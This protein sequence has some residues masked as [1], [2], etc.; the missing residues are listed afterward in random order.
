[1]RQILRALQ[2]RNYRLY[3]AGQGVSLVGTW[4]Q[5]LA[6]SWLVYRLTRSTVLLGTVGFFSQIPSLVVTPLAG[7]LADRGNRLRKLIIIQSL[8]M[9]QAFILAFLVLTG[10]IEVWH[11][12]VLS[13]LLGCVTAFDIPTRQ[14]FVIEMIGQREDLGNAIALNSSLVNGARLIGPSLAGI[15]IAVIGE[16]ACFLLNGISYLAVLGALL[17]MRMHPGERISRRSRIW[18]E[19]REGFAYAFGFSPIRSLL[20]LLALMSLAAISYQVLMPVFAGE[21]LHGGPNTLGFLMGFSGVGALSGSVYL[22][23]RRNVR[24]LGRVI[25]AASLVFGFGMIAFSFSGH[26]WLSMLL[27]IFIGFGIMVQM[28]ACNTILQSIVDDDKRG[29]VMSLFTMAF[30]GTTPFGSLFAGWLA[31]RIG[32]PHTVLAA[33]ICALAGS[34][35]F[36]RR[37]DKLRESV[38]PIYEAKGI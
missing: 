24:G 3:F 11:I 8:A 6:M 28:A 38:R 21:V 35:F 1:M 16:G 29:R 2:H 19:I 22:A 5:T 4:M 31:S 13:A 36:A 17:A 32:A 12:L 33:G 9:L 18:G 26:L 15:M 10:R 30:M 34:L 20:S 25:V 23:S 7:V 37:L 14:S 27:M